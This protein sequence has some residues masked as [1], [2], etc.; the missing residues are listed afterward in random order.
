LA[1]LLREIVGPQQARLGIAQQPLHQ[2]SPADLEQC[3]RRLI[4]AKRDRQIVGRN[5]GQRVSR[6]EGQR[7]MGD[8][9]W[10]IG[11]GI[12]S[13]QPPAPSPQLLTPSPQSPVPI[14]DTLFR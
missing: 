8:G 2:R 5:A 11:V 4:G 1:A 7:G 3:Q 12:T 13:P 14:F 6:D 9:G 10:G